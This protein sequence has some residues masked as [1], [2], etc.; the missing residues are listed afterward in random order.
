MLIGSPHTLNQSTDKLQISQQYHEE[1]KQI[2]SNKPQS[3]M[4]TS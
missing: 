4:K 2:Q 3:R 1:V